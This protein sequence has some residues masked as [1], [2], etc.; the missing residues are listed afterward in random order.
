MIFNIRAIILLLVFRLSLAVQ[1]QTDSTIECSLPTSVGQALNIPPSFT[2]QKLKEQSSKEIYNEFYKGILNQPSIYAV[3]REIV[4]Q[5]KE[6]RVTDHEFWE[7]TRNKVLHLRGREAIS[8][9]ALKLKSMKVIEDN[10]VFDLLDKMIC[11]RGGFIEF[12]ERFRSKGEDWWTR[13][14]EQELEVPLAVTDPGP[15]VFV[16]LPDSIA[17]ELGNPSFQLIKIDD[18]TLT[19]LILDE[20]TVGIHSQIS[21]MEL[22]IMLTRHKDERKLSY[23]QVTR[24]YSDNYEFLFFNERINIVNALVSIRQA[25]PS[26]ADS[27]DCLNVFDWLRGSQSLLEFSRFVKYAGYWKKATDSYLSRLRDAQL[28]IDAQ[29]T[30]LGAYI[31][32]EIPQLIDSNGSGVYYYRFIKITP[33]TREEDMYEEGGNSNLGRL[34]IFNFLLTQ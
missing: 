18:R 12:A 30:N 16:D 19:R 8:K 26:M 15:T 23:D 34:G 2:I 9:A 20:Y 24:W 1:K 3:A 29:I 11:S 25:S 27:Y 32:V 10:D 17:A 31:Q 4:E 14:V 6:G 28:K 21:I 13:A 5:R 22:F 33:T 7:W